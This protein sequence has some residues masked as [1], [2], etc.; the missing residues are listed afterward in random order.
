[1]T[2]ARM[3]PAD[4]AL[5]A[6]MVADRLAGRLA[7]TRSDGGL[8]T[9]AQVAARLSTTPEWVRDHADELGVIRIGMGPRPRL[10]FHPPVIDAWLK[11][12]SESVRSGNAPG[13]VSTG[14]PAPGGRA[15]L[16]TSPTAVPIRQVQP[17]SQHSAPRDVGASGGLAT[18]TGPPSRGERIGPSGRSLPQRE[19]PS[20]RRRIRQD[21][22][23]R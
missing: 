5:L 6:D 19:V 23:T 3:H 1:V 17:W 4:L 11:R 18:E 21:R 14:N 8:L 22:R 7:E 10:R 2:S 16:G 15:A 9:T 13:R 20:N 12:R